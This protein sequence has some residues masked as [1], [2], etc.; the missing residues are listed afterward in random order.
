MFDSALSGAFAGEQCRR[1]LENDADGSHYVGLALETRSASSPEE[2]RKGTY[3]HCRTS[4]ALL[5]TLPADCGPGTAG[6]GN[7]RRRR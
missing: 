3:T 4:P 7:G 1:L 5:R 2:A 6:L